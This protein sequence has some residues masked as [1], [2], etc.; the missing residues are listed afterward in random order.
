MAQQLFYGDVVVAL[1]LDTVV[2]GGI[3]EDALLSEHLVAHAQLL[4]L[5]ELHN[6]GSGDELGYGCKAHQHVGFHADALLLVCPSESMGIEQG[7]VTG[8]DEL[9]TVDFPSLEVSLYDGIH[10]LVCL[11]SGEGI[12][13]GI[14]DMYRRQ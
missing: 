6:A 11:S 13:D 10:F 1:V 7:V 5:Y 12:G 9:G 2:I 14:V 4:H 8:D 3:A